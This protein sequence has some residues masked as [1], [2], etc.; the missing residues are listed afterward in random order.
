M[1]LTKD[2]EI[3][4]PVKPLYYALRLEKLHKICF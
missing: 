2:I 4:W 1:L 3:L